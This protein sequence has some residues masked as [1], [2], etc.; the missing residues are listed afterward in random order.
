M[1]SVV[2]RSVLIDRT[3]P[4]ILTA[5]A[6]NLEVR[7]VVDVYRTAV[8]ALSNTTIVTITAGMTDTANAAGEMEA[9]D[10]IADAQLLAT[11]P[12]AGG[13]AQI[14]FITVAACATLA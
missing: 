9:G 8:S 2:T 3:K 4:A 14:A 1:T 11:Q 12:L 5:I 7:N 10:P 13:D 6:N